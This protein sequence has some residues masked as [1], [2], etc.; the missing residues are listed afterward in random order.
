[1][2]RKVLLAVCLIG[3]GLIS[4]QAQDLG[5]SI[6]GHVPSPAAVLDV[7]ATNKGVLIPRIALSSETH[8]LNGGKNPEG[9]IV[10]NI[11]K[12]L[13]TGFYYWDTTRWEKVSADSQVQE[14][15]TQINNEIKNIT[16]I[17]GGKGDTDISYLVSYNPDSHV[18]TYL[19]PKQGG[20][21]DQMKIDF[22]EAIKDTET[23]TFV[24]EVTT[25][26]EGKEVVSK[27]IY[28]SEKQIT[29]WLKLPGNANKL[30]NTEMEDSLG[31]PIDVLGVVNNNF[32]EILENT[33]NTEIINNIIKD[34]PNNVWIQEKGGIKY[35]V[36]KDENDNIIEVDLTPQETQTS[37]FKYSV[38]ENGKEGVES[39]TDSLDVA[40]LESGDI[41]Y[42]YNAEGGKV[43]YINMTSD[44]INSIEH[45]ETLKKEIFKTVNNYHSTTGGNVYFG[46]VTGVNGDVLYTMDK[47]GNKTQIDISQ[48]ILK[49]IEN[50]VNNSI[51][52]KILEQTAIKVVIGSS[53]KLNETH[54]TLPVYKGK[55]EAHVDNYD[56]DAG[57]LYNTQFNAGFAIADFETLLSVKI[58]KNKQLVQN[59]VTD[60]KYENGALTFKFG[61]GNLHATLLSGDYQVIIDYVATK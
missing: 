6:G 34:A 8:L 38:T 33:N 37:I 41:Y 58:L 36:Y 39:K 53:V 59:S 60:V 43:H 16:N 1:M 11:G 45:N 55:Y 14:Q 26:V 24:R 3:F 12:T 30:P 13:Q 10:Y 9:V 40:K 32:K 44:I 23:N 22:N 51:V 25:T 57:A 4:A 52:E 5:F 20:G 18:F 46:E 61:M 2:K 48:D 17:D 35:L 7:D 21:Y 19:L 31:T 47:D 50:T 49:V 28:F 29:D 54:D 27:Y 56:E 15:I 42:A